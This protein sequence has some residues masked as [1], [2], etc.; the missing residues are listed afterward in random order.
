MVTVVSFEYENLFLSRIKLGQIFL[1]VW[2]QYHTIGICLV[3]FQLCPILC[4]PMDCSPQALLSM[5]ILQARILEWVATHPP[6]DLPNLGIK[7][8]SPALQAD[9][10]PTE[11]PGK[12]PL[13]VFKGPAE[14]PGNPTLFT[15]VFCH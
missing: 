14:P 3:I 4:D 5:A 13:S 9:P 2:L 15:H 11:P 7:P 12:P 6:G 10:L 8:R 1:T